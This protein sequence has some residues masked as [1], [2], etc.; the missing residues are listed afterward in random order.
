MLLRV[1]VVISFMLYASW[2]D[3]KT[4]E[5]SNKVWAVLG[6]V[7]LALTLI[8]MFLTGS[9]LMLDDFALAFLITTGLAIGLFYLGFF[10]GADAKALI[11]LSVSL[12]FIPNEFFSPF[13]S[14]IPFL[15][16]S[17]FFNAIL[18]SI[19]VA[20]YALLRNVFWVASGKP[21]FEGLKS[22]PLSKKLASLFTGYKVKVADLDKIYLYPIEKIEETPEDGITRKFQ[23]FVQAEA[24]REAAV[25]KIEEF[26]KRGL[27]KEV[28]VTPALP[29]LVFITVGL[30]ASLLF[31]DIIF[32]FLSLIWK[33]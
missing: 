14:L 16:I 26:S 1:A 17:V 13:F 32:C 9:Y 3:I 4:R 23:V 5:V 11:C 33:I 6:P 2:S 15:P 31:G 30:F 25:N 12:P 28:W 20:L 24:E 7:G 21:L 18:T 10:G 27:V 19:S 22:E 8:Q 29:F